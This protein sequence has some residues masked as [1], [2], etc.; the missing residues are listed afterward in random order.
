[1]LLGA[2]GLFLAGLVPLALW[3]M[4]TST[5]RARW[6]A[7]L[8]AELTWSV[9]GGPSPSLVLPDAGPYDLRL[10]YAR[11]PEMIQGAGERGFG[12]T[13]TTGWSPPTCPAWRR[14]A[15]GSPAP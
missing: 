10:G 8:A 4:R 1:M 2:V 12:R 9:E 7:P 15:S 5:L 11:L 6:L 14:I 3:E 13:A